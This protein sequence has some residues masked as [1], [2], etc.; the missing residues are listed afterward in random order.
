VTEDELV[1]ARIVV[2]RRITG[3]GDDQV[4]VEGA[5]H[6]SLIEALGLLRFAEGVG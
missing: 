5:E 3:G 4:S 6:L 2:T 1:S